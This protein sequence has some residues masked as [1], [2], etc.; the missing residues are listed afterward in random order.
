MK[1]LTK[2]LKA[3]TYVLP[4]YWA[5]Y[6]I[7]SDDSGMSPRDKEDCHAFLS[8]HVLNRHLFVDCSDQWS[9]GGND[10]NSLYG[11][12]CTFTYMPAPITDKQAMSQDEVKPLLVE[13]L[14]NTR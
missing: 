14:T 2:R 13:G 11:D 6:L 12:V 1:T 9:Q 4:A 5:S 3:Q 10:A 8:R 7:N